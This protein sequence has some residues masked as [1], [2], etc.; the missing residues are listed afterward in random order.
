MANAAPPQQEVVEPAPLPDGEDDLLAAAAVVPANPFTLVTPV[1]ANADGAH[2]VQTG[3]FDRDGQRDVVVASRE[4]GRIVWHR[5]VGGM[6]AQFAPQQIALAPGV[7]T[8]A[9]E[10][11]DRDGRLDVVGA[12]VGTLAPS[13]ADAEQALAGGGSVFWL[14]NNLPAAP[15]FV[16]REIAIGLNYPVSVHVADVEGDGDVDVLAATRDDNRITW[17][18][19]NGALPPAFTPRV[20]TSQAQGAVAVHTADLDEDGKLDILSA[21]ENDGRILWYRNNG[22]RPPAFELRVVRAGPAPP[23]NLDFAKSVFGADVDGDGDDDI[24]YTSEDQNQIGWYENRA[25][26][27]SFVEHV[28]LTDAQHA[29]FA[30]AIDVD[31]DG[32]RDVVAAA[33]GD[34]TTGAGS[35]VAVL[36]NNGAA[37]PQFTSQIISNSLRGVRH[38]TGADVDGD[39]DL[40]LLAASRNDDRVTLFTNNTIH[41]TALFDNSTQFVVGTYYRARGVYAADLD[42]DGD[43]DILAAAETEVAWHE[44]DGKSPPSFVRASDRRL[45]RWRAVGLCGRSGS[46]WGHGRP[47][48]FEAR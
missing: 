28:L 10:D 47:L 27:S 21:S 9:V 48:C 42:K 35:F 36:W 24:V 46:G 40:E 17:Y 30:M 32:D 29:K 25:R 31:Q 12:A 16:R 1:A 34:P 11:I 39:G 14:Q 45:H 41:R 26:A 38:V 15:A 37:V 3:D 6:P 18:E 2:S 33:A 23:P 8:I 20:V 43:L 5:N 4:D 44:N 13:A 7:Y 22:A 19:N